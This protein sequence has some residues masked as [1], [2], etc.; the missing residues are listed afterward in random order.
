MNG[1][2]LFLGNKYIVGGGASNMFNQIY[3]NLLKSNK[4]LYLAATDLDISEEKNDKLLLLDDSSKSVFKILFNYKNYK[5]L[6]NFIK[7]NNIKIVHMHNI[8]SELS[9]SVLLSLKKN[10]VEVIYTLHQFDYICPNSSLCNMNKGIICEKCIGKKIKWN[11]LKEKCS[12]KGRKYDVAKFLISLEKYLFDT[13]KIIKYYIVPSDFSKKKM[14]QEGIKE[15]KIKVIKNFVSNKFW[16]DENNKKNNNIIFFGRFS[17]EKN[18]PLLIEAINLL[19]NIHSD[20]H[21]FIIGKGTTDVEYENYLSQVQKNNLESNITI[22][23]KFLSPN[24]LKKLMKNIKISILPSKWYETFG[25]TIIESIFAN[26][27]PIA[28]NVGAMKETIEDS[29]GFN[30]ENN[31]ARDLANKIDYVLKNYDTEIKKLLQKKE[32]I[33]KCYSLE[34]YINELQKIE[35]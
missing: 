28:T 21:L 25:L 32:S 34:R 8:I 13:D 20:I 6:D 26:V 23:N 17:K 14:L 4:N 24:E 10:K 15:K 11:I 7:K 18:I 5:L 3:N 31:N 16:I 29:F 30:F 27:I 33:K 9:P 2:I 22:I 1:N 19:K 35:V 12:Y